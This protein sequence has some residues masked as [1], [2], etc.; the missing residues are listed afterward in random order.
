M[1]SISD[2]VKPAL[3]D[4]LRRQMSRLEGWRGPQAQEAPPTTTS[5]CDALDRLLPSR[6]FRRGT[7]VEWL[8]THPGCGA[9]TLSLAAALVACQAGGSLV[10]VDRRRQFYPPAV[11]A[12]GAD[13]QT[14]ILVHPR[15]ERAVIWA[16]DQALRCEAVAAVWGRVDK[17]D[18]RSYRRLQLAAET[19]GG[20]GLLVRPA[21]TRGQPTWSDV[22]LLVTPRPTN[23]NRRVR[24]EVIRCRGG[25]SGAAVELEID[26]ST[27]AVRKAV[28]TDESLSVHLAAKLARPAARRRSTG[29]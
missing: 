24:V 20:L 27:G 21:A 8:S 19:G 16:R 10:V 5:G 2:P 7:L 25:T 23:G 9:G 18:A 4:A 28:A 15:S 12:F 3:I 1:L 14:T 26:E 13:L 22:Q 11:A 29:T 17:L 6:G